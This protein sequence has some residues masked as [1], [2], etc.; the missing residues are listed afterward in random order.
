[1][2]PHYSLALLVI[3]FLLHNS[4]T[5]QVF[6]EDFEDEIFDE[7]TF[8]GNGQ[9]FLIINGPTDTQFNINIIQ[10]TGWNG[11]EPDAAYIDN[12]GVASPLNDGAQVTIATDDGTDITVRS[13]F[14]FIS[15]RFLAEPNPFTLTIEGF[16]NGQ[17][18]YTIT[19]TDGFADVNIFQ[20]NNGYTRVD[21]ATDGEQDYS[22]VDVDRIDISTTG[23]ADYM[24]ID[25]FSWG[26]ESA[27]SVDGATL[28][29]NSINIFPNPS[30]STITVSGIIKEENYRIYNV[31][32]A[33]ITRGV[34]SDNE[35]ISIQNLSNG[36][37]LIEFDNGN[38]IKFIKK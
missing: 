13:F 3:G 16:S 32:G 15:T 26:P 29:E 19:K 8:N 12:S 37:Y 9:G 7:T 27:L 34:I 6:L 24:G 17:S 21:F 2:K 35:T 36:L 28:G 20:P 25:A 1:M 14:A 4:L 10:T 5:A 31:L 18:V 38:P 33:E 11:T 23:N 22:R 30:S